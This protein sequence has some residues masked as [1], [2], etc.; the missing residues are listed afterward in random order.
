M[1]SSAKKF[2]EHLYGQ[3]EA[4]RGITHAPTPEGHAWRNRWIRE[5]VAGARSHAWEEH[6]APATPENHEQINAAIRQSAGKA[7]EDS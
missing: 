2:S 6:A 1:P 4:G 5:A 3:I 7:D